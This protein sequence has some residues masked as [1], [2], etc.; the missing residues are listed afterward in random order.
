MDGPPPKEEKNEASDGL[1]NSCS[2]QIRLD[3]SY[4]FDRYFCDED[5]K[6]KAAVDELSP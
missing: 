6:D 1:D 2:V 3:P 5:I 4:F